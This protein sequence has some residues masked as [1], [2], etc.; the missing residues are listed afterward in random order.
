MAYLLPS[1]DEIRY[2]IQQYWQGHEDVSKRA[3]AG[4]G[5]FVRMKVQATLDRLRSLIRAGV[6]PHYAETQAMREIALTD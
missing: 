5:E 2:L 4:D 6:D 1:T 3:K